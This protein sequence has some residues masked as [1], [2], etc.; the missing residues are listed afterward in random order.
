MLSRA[1]IGARRS[2]AIAIAAL[3]LASPSF[4]DVALR[5]SAFALPLKSELT[6]DVRYELDSTATPAATTNKRVLPDVL[7][8][9]ALPGWG[10]LHSGHRNVGLAFLAAEA[11]LWTTVGVSVGQG[12][13]RRGSSEDVAQIYA[14][15]DLDAHADNFRKLI[16][17]F[18]S[19][20]EYNRLVVYREA[21]ALYYGDYQR[22]N[23]YIDTHSLSGADSWNW[24]SD[25]QWERYRQLRRTSERAFQRA[26]FA[27]AGAIVN[28]VAAAIVSSRLSA[29]SSG[30]SAAQAPDDAVAI[31]PVQWSV[32]PV[33]DAPLSL[34]HRISWV[35]HFE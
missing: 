23:D 16:S 6:S 24:D 14:D 22:F 18:R 26:R 12:R 28:R 3:T 8:S 13:L 34:R 31:G 35:L 29:R 4:A 27:A 15:I 20:D 17:N 10:A 19:S 21:A 1:G 2:L 7:R 5:P 9:L 32:E 30:T 33:G 25:D 11:A